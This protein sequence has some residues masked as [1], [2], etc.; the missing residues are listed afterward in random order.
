MITTKMLDSLTD[1][2]IL[3]FDLVLK[4]KQNVYISEKLN[5]PMSKITYILN[6]I[7]YKLQ[8]QPHSRHKLRQDWNISVMSES[9]KPNLYN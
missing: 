1:E 5:I 9:K 7:Y 4:L 2:E 8:V 3:V 6:R